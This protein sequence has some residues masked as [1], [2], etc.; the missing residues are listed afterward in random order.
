MPSADR[1]QVFIKDIK[2]KRGRTFLEIT[3]IFPYLLTFALRD[4]AHIFKM[5]ILFINPSHKRER[6]MFSA[7]PQ[8]IILKCFSVSL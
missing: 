5:V 6:V 1:R 8:T 3:A 2:A 4:R 7:L